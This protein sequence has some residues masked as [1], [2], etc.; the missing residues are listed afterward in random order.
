[1]SIRVSTLCFT[2]LAP[3]YAGVDPLGQLLISPFGGEPTYL[4]TSPIYT[5]VSLRYRVTGGLF[6]GYDGTATWARI[7]ID[8]NS[9]P[10]PAFYGNGLD[11]AAPITE[12]ADET[13]CTMAMCY[14]V[15]S[16]YSLR[17]FRD[18]KKQ[19][20]LISAKTQAITSG[21]HT[22]NLP[23]PLFFLDPA[24]Y[25]ASRR[26]MRYFGLDIYR[27]V[28]SDTFT[29]APWRD[30]RGTYSASYTSNGV[31]EQYDWTIA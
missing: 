28:D 8:S 30:R 21:A 18:P 29:A 14:E 19:A 1:M 24:T 22:L 27:C 9:Y 7:A 5:S 4:E 13:K 2:S 23:P 31:T 17:W 3:S 11:L 12:P 6:T 20:P 26:K 16:D 10:D 25:P 15:V